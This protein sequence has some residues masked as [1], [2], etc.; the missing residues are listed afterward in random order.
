MIKNIC[1]DITTYNIELVVTDK[2]KN[3]LVEEGYHQDFGA[4]P[5]RRVLQKR[6]VDEL[7][8]AFVEN[9]IHQGDT[10]KI[11]FD[12]N[13]FEYNTHPKEEAKQS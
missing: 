6:I 4:R 9:K 3:Q 8:L 7:S 12:G 13:Q 10:Y 2:A 5:L 11:D 1:S